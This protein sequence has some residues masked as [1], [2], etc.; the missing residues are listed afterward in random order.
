[1]I[2]QAP[3]DLDSFKQ[4]H[5]PRLRAAKIPGFEGPKLLNLKLNKKLKAKGEDP[6]D[7]ERDCPDYLG[8]RQSD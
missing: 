3:Q 1:M 7:L 8:A 4:L 6:V 2:V 5:L